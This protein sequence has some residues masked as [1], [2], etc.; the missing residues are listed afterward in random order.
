MAGTPKNLNVVELR[1]KIGYV[2]Q[3]IGLFPN[4]TVEE[5][6]SVVPRLLKWSKERCHSRAKELL[7]LVAC[8]CGVRRE[9]IPTELSGGQQQRVGV[10][11]ALARAAH[12][13]DGPSRLA[14]WTPSPAIFCRTKTKALQQRLHIT[15]VFVR[16]IWARL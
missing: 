13:A 12:R 6:I 1:R 16:T 10:L 14:R 5:N 15:V 2:I 3:Q 9:N 11:R 7:E 4:M 8:L